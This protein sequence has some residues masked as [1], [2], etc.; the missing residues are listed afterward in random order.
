MGK[1][2][3]LKEPLTGSWQFIR[4]N[5][6]NNAQLLSHGRVR[7]LKILS[8]IIGWK[9]QEISVNWIF[10]PII[11]EPAMSPVENKLAKILHHALLEQQGK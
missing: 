8:W 10:F 6:L 7:G 5:K 1:H 11:V 2:S 9:L 4:G 3:L